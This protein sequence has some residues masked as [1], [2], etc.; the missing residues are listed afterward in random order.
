MGITRYDCRL[1]TRCPAYFHFSRGEISPLVLVVVAAT[2]TMFAFR[3]NTS[4]QY[5]RNTDIVPKLF[6]IV[7]KAYFL[8]FQVIK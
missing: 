2:T 1:D 3:N 8:D 6:D 5:Q 7:P 4:E